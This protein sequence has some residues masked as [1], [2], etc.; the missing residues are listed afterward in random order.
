MLYY[1]ALTLILTLFL[2]FDLSKFQPKTMSLLGYP[3]VIPKFG[4]FGIIPS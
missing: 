2:I 4:H 1:Y 3:K